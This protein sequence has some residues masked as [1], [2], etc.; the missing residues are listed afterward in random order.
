MRR[1]AKRHQRDRRASGEEDLHDSQLALGRGG[2]TSGLRRP[3]ALRWEEA[4]AG[5]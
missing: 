2:H 1:V 4:S 3:L 5:L